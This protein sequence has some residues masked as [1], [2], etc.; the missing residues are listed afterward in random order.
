MVLNRLHNLKMVP[1]TLN[2]GNYKRLKFCGGRMKTIYI[3]SIFLMVILLAFGC[4]EKKDEAAQLEKE[5]MGQVEPDSAAIADS[6]ARM[7]SI[8][9]ATEEEMNA[10]AVPEEPEREVMPSKPAGT[11]YTVQVAGCE[12]SDYAQYLVRTYQNRGYEPYVTTETVDGQLYNRV[13]IGVF[14]SFGDA[15]ALRTELS[16]KYSINAWIDLTN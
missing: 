8:A 3:T 5:M 16:D 7:D 15:K 12:N 2:V 14:D 9:A 4:S 10:R 6:L 13:R 1:P 11:G